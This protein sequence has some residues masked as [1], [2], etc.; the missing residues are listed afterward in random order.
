VPDYL[1]WAVQ[2]VS[3][4]GDTRHYDYARERISMVLDLYDQANYIGSK[5]YYTPRRPLTAANK[6][7]PQTS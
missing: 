6:I 5:H 2:R 7:G 3:E 1:G 4:R